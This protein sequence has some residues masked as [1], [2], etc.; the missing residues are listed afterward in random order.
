MTAP[1]RSR[2]GPTT[3]FTSR[4]CVCLAF[5]LSG[6]RLLPRAVEKAAIVVASTSLLPSPRENISEYMGF[7]IGEYF[8]FAAHI[9][10]EAYEFLIE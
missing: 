1:A 7:D 6:K 3:A 4:L 2:A 10:Y 9:P 5:R 8:N